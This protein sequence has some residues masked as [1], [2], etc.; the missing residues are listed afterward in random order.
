MTIRWFLILV[1][2]ITLSFAIYLNIKYLKGVKVEKN[3]QPIEKYGIINTRCSFSYK[4]SS[5]VDISFNGKMYDVSASKGVCTD[6][7]KGIAGHK[8]YYKED[9]DELFFEGE[10]LPFPYVYLTYIAAIVFPLIGFIV[11]RKELNNDYRTM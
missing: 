11:Y 8:L 6:M 4:M 9:T 2:I 7:E 3:T 1:F 5:H 10:Y